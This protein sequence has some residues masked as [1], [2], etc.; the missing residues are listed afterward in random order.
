MTKESGFTWK[1]GMFVVLGLGLF[2]ITVYFI[3][4]QKN[5]FGSTFH[6]KSKFKTVSG[7][8]PGNNVRFSG[9]NV[10]TVDE[11]TILTDTCVMVSLVIKNEVQQ[12]IK[13]DARASISS[14]GLMGDKAL[15]IYPGT[16]D[17]SAVK[18]NSFILSKNPIEMDDVM[19]SVKSSVDN[20][21]I[22]TDQLAQFTYKLNN[23]KGALSKLMND[24]KFGNT[25]DATMTNLKTGSKGLSD[26][27]EAAKSNF[28]LK[29]F[30][31]KKKR[32]EEKKQAD[33]KKQE[34]IKKEDAL[35]KKADSKNAIEK[36]KKD[37]TA[38]Q[39]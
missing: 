3:G 33:L 25:L 5:I 31:N 17:R 13:Q 23:G 10:G 20:I 38:R 26:N 12:F 16:M 8:K 32:A 15:T 28:L 21:D 39:Q 14:D 1:L 30:F 37:T 34:E 36:K 2:F 6:L 22:I 7:L 18:D 11:I 4:K 9:I 19:I 24:E 27:M 35:K 29:G